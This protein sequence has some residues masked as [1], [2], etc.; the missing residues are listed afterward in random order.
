MTALNAASDRFRTLAG[1]LR[2]YAGAR[3]R[4]AGMGN[5]YRHWER[6]AAICERCPMRVIRCGVSYCGNPLLEQ[7]DRDPA[8]EGCGCPC[9]DKAQSP[10]EHCPIDSRHQA[11]QR[12]QTGCTCKWCQAAEALP[13]RGQRSMVPDP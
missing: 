6:R 8:T 3:L 13:S 7:I 2:R 12:A 9:H 1:A 4:R 11:A 10:T 5:V